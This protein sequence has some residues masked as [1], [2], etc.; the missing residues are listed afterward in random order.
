MFEAKHVIIFFPF[1]SEKFFKLSYFKFASRWVSLKTFVESQIIAVIPS[2][3]IS[4]HIHLLSISGLGSIFQSPVWNI[5][6]FSVFKIIAF[7]SGIECVKEQ[8]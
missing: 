6:P 2:L 8:I 5:L 4:F 7:G 3:H 1:F